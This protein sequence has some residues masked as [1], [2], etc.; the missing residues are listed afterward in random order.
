[1]RLLRR[2]TKFVSSERCTCSQ[3]AVHG[4]GPLVETPVAS[5]QLVQYVYLIAIKEFGRSSK[6]SHHK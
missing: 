4:P 3:H 5:A 2:K 6:M 1:M